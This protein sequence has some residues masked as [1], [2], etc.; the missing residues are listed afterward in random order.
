MN[1]F[2]LVVSVVGAFSLGALA[3]AP[4]QESAPRT[5]VTVDEAAGTVTIR[6]GG[7]DVVVIDERGLYVRGDVA[8]RG[9]LTDGLPARVAEGRHAP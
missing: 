3:S 8:Y 1:R 2:I 6:A 7:R 4:A 9:T 5:A